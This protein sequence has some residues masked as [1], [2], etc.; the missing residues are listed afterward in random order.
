MEIFGVRLRRHERFQLDGVNDDTSSDEE[1]GSDA[2][3]PEVGSLWNW[4]HVD[5]PGTG[6]R[7]RHKGHKKSKLRTSCQAAVDLVKRNKGFVILLVLVGYFVF[8]FFSGAQLPDIRQPV[9]ARRRSE[10]IPRAGG[11]SAEGTNDKFLK[12]RPPPRYVDVET[13]L[14]Q[15]QKPEV[16]EEAQYQQGTKPFQNHGQQVAA[17]DPEVAKLKQDHSH[18]HNLVNAPDLLQGLKLAGSSAESE[19]DIQ[20][21]PFS[22]EDTG[23]WVAPSSTGAF[24]HESVRTSYEKLV[25]RY[26]A[27]FVKEGIPRAKLVEILNR[28][29]YAESPD[30]ANKGKQSVLFQIKNDSKRIAE[31]FVFS[32]RENQYVVANVLG[33]CAQRTMSGSRKTTSRSLCRITV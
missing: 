21:S 24:S 30:G 4:Q 15:I 2:E 22:N 11:F 13:A 27:P 33:Q 8:Y 25:Q 18:E 7:G 3:D 19:G 14:N 29:T 28:R 23:L 26:L 6:S 9:D 10:L 17:A 1:H 12:L 20:K 32:V 16:E 5:G 31:H